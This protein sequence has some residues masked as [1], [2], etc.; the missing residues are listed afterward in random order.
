MFIYL[1]KLAELVC[2]N[3]IPFIQYFLGAVGMVSQ[4]LLL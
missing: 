3:S 2:H 4:V 1:F